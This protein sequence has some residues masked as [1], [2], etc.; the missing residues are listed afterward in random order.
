MHYLI[1]ISSCTVTYYSLR[2]VM[3]FT[4]QDI[5]TVA[6]SKLAIISIETDVFT[7]GIV[8][9]AVGKDIFVPLCYLK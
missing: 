9:F 6:P 3:C 5:V 7:P 1:F 8:L 2:A 4:V